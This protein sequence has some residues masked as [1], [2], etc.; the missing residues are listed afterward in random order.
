MRKEAKTWEEDFDAKFKASPVMA[1]QRL[2]LVAESGK[3]LSR[4]PA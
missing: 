2:C 4:C 1:G 3:A